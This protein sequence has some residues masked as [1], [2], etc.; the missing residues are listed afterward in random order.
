MVNELTEA[1]FRVAFEWSSFANRGVRFGQLVR[2]IKPVQER[3]TRTKGRLGSV[4]LAS[5]ALGCGEPAG[6]RDFGE[7]GFILLSCFLF[8]LA[9]GPSASERCCLASLPRAELTQFQSR[10]R[11]LNSLLV[12]SPCSVPVGGENVG[13]DGGGSAARPFALIATRCC[14]QVGYSTLGESPPLLIHTFV[15]KQSN[16]ASFFKRNGSTAS[17]AVLTVV[18]F[19]FVIIFPTASAATRKIRVT[20]YS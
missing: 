20:R 19:I 6:S 3:K 14:N 7:G 16:S 15:G 18:L 5:N 9:G 17:N 2:Q 11:S 13:A 12:G 4:D 8:S 1:L 10:P